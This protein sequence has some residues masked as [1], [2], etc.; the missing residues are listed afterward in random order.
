VAAVTTWWRGYKHARFYLFSWSVLIVISALNIF[1]RMGLITLNEILPGQ[2]M[3]I[4]AVFV[5]AFQSL[6]LADR[7][8]LFKQEK[9]DAQAALVAEHAEAL[10]LKDELNQMLEH[11]RLELEARVT[12]RTRAITDANVRLKQEIIERKQ[13]EEK[14]RLF[15]QIVAY[16]GSAIEVWDRK[17]RLEFVNPA[18]TRITGFT[19]EEVRGKTFDE[20]QSGLTPPETLGN[21]WRAAV[22]ENI[23]HGELINRT[24][25]GDLYWSLITIAPVKDEQGT[26]THYVAI[27]DDITARKHMEE[28]ERQFAS[29]LAGLNEINIQL[30]REESFDEVCRLAVELGRSK[31]GFERLS[32]WFIDLDDPAY[33]L[34]SYGVDEAGQVRDERGLRYPTNHDPAHDVLRTGEEK[35]YYDQHAPI[36][37]QHANVLGHGEAAAAG[38]WDGNRVIGFLSIDSFLTGNKI[39]PR[40]REVLTLYAQ[41]LGH[42]CTL[43][44]TTQALRASEERYRKLADGVPTPVLVLNFQGRILYGNQRAIDMFEITL[45]DRTV[46][47]DDFYTDVKERQYILQ[48]LYKNG[49]IPD[50]EV[51][52]KTARGTPFWALMSAN[53]TTYEGQPAIFVALGDITARKLA[54]ESV[55]ASEERYRLLAENITDVIYTMDM[56]MKYTYVSPS[57]EKLTGFTAEEVMKQSTNEALTPESAERA[58]RIVREDLEKEYQGLNPPDLWRAIELQRICKDGSIKWIE[59]RSQY[60]RD[61]NGKPIGLIGVTRD[62]DAN[63]KVEAELRRAKEAAEAANRAKSAFLANMSHELRTP[64]NVILG[65]ADLMARDPHMPPAHKEQLSVINRSG[66]HLLM[67]INNI[68]DLSKIEAGRM[69]LNIS[70]FS[71]RHMLDDLEEMFKLRA[72]QKHLALEF[73]RGGDVPQYVSGDE[74]RLRQILI[75]LLNN[76]VKFTRIGQIKLR[77]YREETATAELGK[78]L[79][80]LTFAVADTG[81]GMST[82]EKN[83]VFDAFM[84]TRDG[85]LS[86]EGTGLGLAISRQFVK[87]MGSDID[88]QS[89]PGHGAVFSF[90]IEMGVVDVGRRTTRPLHR[91]AIALAPGQ[92]TYRLLIVDDRWDNRQVLIRMLQPFGFD[93]REAGTGSEALDLVLSWSPHLVWM[94]MRMP[95]MDGYEATRHIKES[96][97]GKT[98]KV[99]ALTASAFEEERNQV[100]AAGCDDFLRKP[101]RNREIFDALE[102]HLGVRFVYAEPTPIAEEVEDTAPETD[103]RLRDALSAVPRSTLTQLAQAAAR[104]DIHQIITLIEE[105]RTYNS[106]SADIILTKANEFDYPAIVRLINNAKGLNDES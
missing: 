46:N 85:R 35:V 47:I 39:S 30:A 55:R 20:L 90:T 49:S 48:T 74:V 4:G 25:N 72:Q 12:D 8:N 29:M 82:E 37:D 67:L 65:F 87:L 105:V 44:R 101:A 96:E 41:M 100:L 40:Q 56:T 52:L 11:S 64:L 15:G 26:L 22:N 81:Q 57:I 91:R 50:Y 9:Q 84:Q 58:A 68:L 66:E 54:E 98:I 60:L 23:A 21:M 43:K 63:K 3:Q 69:Q 17:G 94:D 2:V 24:K 33:M 62:I 71:L 70:D 93:L 95:G 102:K 78:R 18:F 6:A 83:R 77:V 19:L 92:P 32:L 31:L 97:Q 80:R 10:R 42:L 38:L 88:I 51:R 34:G 104:A 14:L 36:Y 16:S 99:I 79:A 13:T 76:A 61:K 59:T 89:M 1:H 7:I 28:A 103:A 27:E 75:N 106:A 53:I 45:D 86:Q 5:V 73:E